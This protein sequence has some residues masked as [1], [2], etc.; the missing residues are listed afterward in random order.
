MKGIKLF[1]I[2]YEEGTLRETK[3]WPGQS[4]EHALKRFQR[5]RELCN[6][7]PA[8]LVAVEELKQR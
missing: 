1:L 2:T 7:H 5:A 8:K 4:R 3:E 6:K